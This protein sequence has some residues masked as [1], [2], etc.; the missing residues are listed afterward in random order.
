[1]GEELIG[2]AIGL[3]RAVGMGGARLVVVGI[4][5]EEGGGAEGAGGPTRRP[6]MR[7]GSAVHGRSPLRMMAGA[8]VMLD[9]GLV[10]G[11]VLAACHVAAM[12]E[13]ASRWRRTVW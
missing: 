7:E 11:R 10:G 3:G 9:R 8:D 12:E 2:G 4:E 1:M 6:A 13:M 5:A